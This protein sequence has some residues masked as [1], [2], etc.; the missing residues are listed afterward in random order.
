MTELQISA[1]GRVRMRQ[2][3]RRG[4]DIELLLRSATQ[5]APDA[6]LL[7]E[8]DAQREISRRKRE[9]ARLERL[10]G[11]K[12]VIAAGTVVTCYPSRR[13]DQKRTIRRGRAACQRGEDQS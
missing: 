13:D 5:V 9:I 3:G 4:D 2:R 10:K 1:H 6:Y 7:T 8:S 11:W 12:L